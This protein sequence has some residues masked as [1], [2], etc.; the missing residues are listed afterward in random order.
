MNRRN[1]LSNGLTAVLFGLPLGHTPF[2]QWKVYRQIHLF[3][4][5]NREDSVAYNLGQAISET[6]AT[7]LPESRAMVTRAQNILRLASL[8]ST[9]Q[10]DLALIHRSE[11]VAWQH[12]ENPFDQIEPVALKTLFTIEDY[13][14]IGREDFRMEH[15]HLVRQTLQT[16][17]DAITLALNSKLS[18]N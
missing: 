17:P 4:V 1:F 12:A 3:I 16:H 14:L 7:E 8:I 11:L 5:V 10:L 15:A 18:L 2:P 9:H 13:V 6:L